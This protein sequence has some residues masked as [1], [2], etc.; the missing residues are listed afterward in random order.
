M[1]KLII[2]LVLTP[3]I[4]TFLLSITAIPHK[5]EQKEL[6]I[7]RTILSLSGFSVLFIL[8]F[9]CASD[10]LSGEVYRYSLGG[11]DALSGIVLQLDILSFCIAVLSV[12]VCFFA[13]VY[14][15]TFMEH[16]RGLG[17]FDAF[18]FLMI[19]GIMGVLVSRDI[20]NMYVFFEIVNISVY[21]LITTGRKKEN[22]K[23]SL[24]Y[25][26]LESISSILF[27]L[28]VGII[29]STIGS[30][31]MDY[32]AEGIS[33]L[34]IEQPSLI[35]LL[36]S[37]FFVSLGL[38]F[39]VVPLHFWLPDSYFAAPSPVSTVQSG[40]VSKIGI[41]AMIRI[42]S[43]FGTLP[44]DMNYFIA[45]MGAMTI[46]TGT[47]CALVQTDIKRMLAYSSI[48]QIGVIIIGLGIG[49]PIAMK[50]ALFHIMNH[51][52]AKAGLF[53]CA[54]I[55][56]HTRGTRKISGM[57]FKDSP[58]LTLSFILLS[59]SIIGIP[60]LNGFVSKLIICY[61]AIGAHFSEF[62]FII[63]FSSILSSVY[64]F[65]VI[66]TFFPKHEKKALTP[67]VH[68][69]TSTLLPIYILAI[70]CLLLGLFPDTALRIIDIIV[71][72]IL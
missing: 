10:M 61:G 46:I 48:N 9:L 45:V 6:M 21:V 24:K 64:Y 31:N 17:K 35:I 28:A 1:S 30:L 59:L 65:R 20:F 34:R 22:Y 2:L 15:F 71:E 13:L 18:F 55:L 49:N 38:K 58:G 16:M 41:Y 50:G 67:D 60:P 4:T 57:K 51:A 63:F 47:L 54:G 37:L 25:L 8:L 43:L 32:I 40:I 72:V 11:W 69:S 23:A 68:V 42:L 7:I 53:L 12:V 36:F 19:T 26:I 66:Q 3:M 33:L 70:M 5:V 27:L 44:S 39:G 29:Y 56:I 62:T 14:S 52:L